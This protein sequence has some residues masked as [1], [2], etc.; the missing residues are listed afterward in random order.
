VPEWLKPL[1]YVRRE[2]GQDSNWNNYQSRKD[3]FGGRDTR[4]EAVE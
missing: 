4:F 3:T 1:Q 2:G